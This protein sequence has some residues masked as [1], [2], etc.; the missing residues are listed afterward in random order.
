MNPPRSV[1]AFQKKMIG[2]Q[3]H[4]LILLMLHI[5]DFIAYGG[6]QGIFWQADMALA[7]HK[8]HWC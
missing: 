2:T 6:L 8:T 7:R 4:E 3:R 5:S 1:T